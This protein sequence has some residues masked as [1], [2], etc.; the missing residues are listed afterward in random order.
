MAK[1]KAVKKQPD[2][3]ESFISI[4]DDIYAEEAM[5]IM[6]TFFE[7]GHSHLQIALE[8][9]KV[10]AEKISS[11]ASNADTVEEIFQIFK[12]ASSVVIDSSPLREIFSKQ[13]H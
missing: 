12:Q 3:Q 10:I 2:P 5:E 9:T 1:T 11:S 7:A 8:L 4:M 13:K 6:P